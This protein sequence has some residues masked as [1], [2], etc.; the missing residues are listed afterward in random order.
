MY[1]V[2]YIIINNSTNASS[3]S[4]SNI[5]D[6]TE[7]AVLSNSVVGLVLFRFLPLVTTVLVDSMMLPA[8][9]GFS[10]PS[11]WHDVVAEVMR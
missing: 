2:V 9:H 10:I 8:G 6:R 5:G 4:M 7:L 3:T 11:E 1:I